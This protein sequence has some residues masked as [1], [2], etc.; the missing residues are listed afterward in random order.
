[1][2]SVDISDTDTVSWVVEEAFIKD[3]TKIAKKLK[4]VH[5]N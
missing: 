4:P 3:E 1:M 5:S 2:K